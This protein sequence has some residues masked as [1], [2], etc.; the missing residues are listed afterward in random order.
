MNTLLYDLRYGIR[1][2]LKNPG[3]TFAALITLALGIASSTAI[4][5]VIDGVLLHPL[6]YPDSKKIMMVLPTM[7][8]TGAAGGAVAPANYID[9]AAQNDVFTAMSASRGGQFS[10]SD[11]DRPERVRGTMTTSNMFP[12]FGVAPMIGRTLLPSDEQPGHNHVVVL[13][14]EL[15]ARRYGSDR[16]IIGR[17]ISLNDEP[18]TV[19]GIMPPN[20]EPDGY[21]ELWVPSAFGIPTNSI[22]PNVDP[23]PIRGSNY[24]DVYARLKPGVTLEKA[25][26]EMDAIG[27]RLEQQ[28]SDDNKDVGIRV[29]PLHETLVGGV[30]PVL[31][32]LFAAVG[33][34]LFIGCANVA[35]LLLARAATRSREISIRAAMGASRTRLIRQL[36]TESVLLA[37][38]GGAIGAL[39]A[40]WAIPLLMAMAPPALRSFKEV[41]LN[42]QVL[43]FSLGVSVVTGI[44]FGLVPAISSSSANPAESLKQGERGSTGGGSRRRAFL[45]A[46]EVGLSLILL[47]GAGL[48]IKSFANVT[49]V[50]PGFNHDRLLIFNVGASAKADE[51]Q[52]LQFYQQI[53]QQVATVPGVQDVAAI[54]RLPF[55]GGNSSRTFNRPGRTK[56]DQA[57][58]RIAT[59]DYFQ[60]MGMPFVR[61]RNFNQ[62]DTKDSTRVTI[63]NEECAKQV[64]PG[65][66]PIGQFVENFG[67]KDEKLQVV[68]VVGNV[69]HLALETAPRPE[70]YQ[71]LG[72]GMWPSLFVAV[73]TAPEN[74]L[75]LLP[76][77]QQAV[78]N[79]NKSVP[80]GNPRTMNEIIAR[81]LLQKKFT[82]LLLSIFAGAALLLAAIGLY[83]VISYSVAQRTRELGIRI[84]LGAQRSDVLH[85]ILRQGMTLVA[86]GV[87]FGIAASLGLTRLIASLLYGISASD[88]ITFFLLSTALVL[89]AFVACWLPARRA[90][91]VDPIVA[92]HA[93]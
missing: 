81:T 61:G 54:S 17:E 45:I 44:L 1:M 73:R 43:E 79:V 66:D 22:R 85:L 4:F 35:N 25:R 11:S 93:E 28:Y 12:L 55:S 30:R 91:A 29:T 50:D 23:H 24:L 9:W 84:A 52:Q 41:G 82:M 64:F 18:H 59:S 68:G 37:L 63:I 46:T 33:F 71:P 27:R 8:T 51:A 20:Y 88:P 19:V 49:K 34:L 56:I 31:L 39:L 5:S 26:A 90:S 57:D 78:W 76:A 21:G 15:W 69:R 6:Q 58:I 92:L 67:P 89:V 10:L 36:L 38:I 3:F 80:L 16:N 60:T 75:T 40:A 53:V 72:Q 13:S 7:R 65:E 42:G 32:L 83:G 86:A 70:L 48:M 77:V 47:I 87:I 14:S 62:S 2:L 74:P